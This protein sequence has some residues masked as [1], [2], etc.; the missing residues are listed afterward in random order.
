MRFRDRSTDLIMWYC[1]FLAA[2]NSARS[3][4][5]LIQRG[6]YRAIGYK[7][8]RWGIY[9][10]QTNAATS[11]ISILFQTLFKRPYQD[12]FATASCSKIFAK[13][14]RF[15]SQTWIFEKLTFWRSLKKNHIAIRLH[16]AAHHHWSSLLSNGFI[17][18]V[19]LLSVQWMMYSRIPITRTSL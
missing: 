4:Q 10:G 2:L 17:C 12:T 15:S 6:N 16:R 9:F 18:R 13:F 7:S 11:K 3:N 14:Q 8:S 5:P 1:I 19:H